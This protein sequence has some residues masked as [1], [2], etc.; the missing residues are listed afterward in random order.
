MTM[1]ELYKKVMASQELKTSFLEAAKSDMTL[2]DWLKEQG[3][4]NTPEEVRAFL[5]EQNSKKGEIDDD[6]LE[7]VAGGAGSGSGLFQEET[8][9]SANLT[10]SGKYCYVNEWG[11]YE[12]TYYDAVTRERSLMYKG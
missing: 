6:E 3:C 12:P 10:E 8:Q 4:G 5:A 11:K 7:A 9:I 2:A 1:K